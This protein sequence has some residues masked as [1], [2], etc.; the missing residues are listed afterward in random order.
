METIKIT[1]LAKK[2]NITH[3]AISQWKANNK[4]PDSK[5]FIIAPIISVNVE[6]LYRNNN[7]LFDLFNNT[8][9]DDDKTILKE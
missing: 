1:E 4:I 8:K 9:K 5:I 7:L 6:E 2:L 3:S